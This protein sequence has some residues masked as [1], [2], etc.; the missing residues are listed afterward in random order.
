MKYFVWSIMS[1]FC[2]HD[3]KHEEEFF[4][5]YDGYGGITKQGNKVSATC[6]KCGWHRSYWKYNK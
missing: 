4:Q 6:R 1:A 2:K 3:W 5:Q